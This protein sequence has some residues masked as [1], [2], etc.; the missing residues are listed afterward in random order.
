[1]TIPLRRRVSLVS[2]VTVGVA[3][4]VACAI[5]YLAVSHELHHQVDDA[6][7]DQAASIAART[8]LG[9]P[10]PLE[11]DLGRVPQAR[12]RNGGP[13]GYVQVLT[14]DGATTRPPGQNVRLPVTAADRA[15]IGRSAVARIRDVH[16]QGSHLRMLTVHVAPAR[17]VQLA[18][19]L[20]G[21]DRL[22]ARLRLILLLAI[23][24]GV[25]L[26]ALLGRAASKRLMAPIAEVAAAA[27]HVGETE[28]LARRI[29]VRYEDEVGQLARRFNAMLDRLQE[30]RGQL[31]EAMVA[32]RRL[33]ADA[34][35]ELRTPVTSL[36]MNV[37]ML[38]DMGDRLDA[39]ARDQLLADL[40]A[41]TEEMGALVADLIELARGDVPAH[42]P[43]AIRLDHLTDAAVQR[44]QLH[45][46]QV[47]FDLDATP[48]VVDG[49]PDR[50]S[51]ALNK[52]L[53]NAARHSPDG[54]TVD[55]LVHAG[56]VVV[57]DRGDGI[58]P[59]DLPHLFD[60]F[61]RGASSRGRQG[62][63]LGLTIVRQVAEQH[64]GAVRVENAVG[65]GARF[66]L[67]LPAAPMAS[68]STSSATA[69]TAAFR[70]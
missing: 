61:Y 48:A 20:D 13:G 54:A 56:G 17:A 41:Q 12:P 18:R 62:T 7:R 55:V 29:D 59:A 3:V 49:V 50:L 42:E 39:D 27:A 46:P 11:T 21:I 34:S 47:R 70:P 45:A 24:G 5:A 53:D 64:G 60:R 14:A 4:V 16:V 44:A 68:T 25:G 40:R 2:A 69:R 6:L 19:P 1:V 8:A 66:T 51:R 38:T 15:Q 33:V 23:A 52:L 65:G 58:A 10:R 26:A 63:G 57:R 43:E 67:D 9:R 36:R 32:Q 37:E 22:L 30:S 28:D 31:D 35:H